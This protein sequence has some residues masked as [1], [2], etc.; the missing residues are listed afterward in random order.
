MGRG[1]SSKVDGFNI[2]EEVALVENSSGEAKPALGGNER[3]SGGAYP[4]R[5]RAT[6]PPRLYPAT[7]TFVTFFPSSSS[8][9]TRAST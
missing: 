5:Y 8:S 7:D 6:S 3:M 1:D 2:H 4:M 9:F